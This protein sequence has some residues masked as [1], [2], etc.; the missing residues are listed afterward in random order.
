MS[1]FTL[2]TTK[3]SHL[4]SK[5]LANCW[6]AYSMDTPN[7]EI[8]EVG[9]NKKSGYIYIALENQVC[10]ASNNGNPVEYIISDPYDGAEESFDSYD[11]A[12]LTLYK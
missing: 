12:V 7:H 8:M 5:G 11:E 3:L 4:Q 2:D 1:I 10:I 6:N 9:L